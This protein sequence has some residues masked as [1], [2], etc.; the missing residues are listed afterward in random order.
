MRMKQSRGVPVAAIAVLAALALSSSAWGQ[1]GGTASARLV[2]ADG[3]AAGSMELTQ[4]GN[5]VSVTAI[6]RG[7][8]AGFHGF[9]IHATGRCDRPTFA[10]AGGHF[11]R[12]GAAH[13]T[14][15]GDLPPLLVTRRGTVTASFHADRFTVSQLL[16]AD[17]AAIVVH[18]AADNHANIPTDRYD[19]DPDAT[20]LA[21]GDA[22]PRIACG[23]LRPGEVF[24][25]TD[26][27]PVAARA[28]LMAGLGAPAGYV[29]LSQGP[30][31]VQL[32]GR[33]AGVARGFHGFH[34]H[35]R[36]SCAGPSFESAGGH[37]DRAGAAHPVHAG[38]LPTVLVDENGFGDFFFLETDRLRLADLLG[39]DGT[40]FVVHANADNFANIPS[41]RYDPD[42][43]AATTATGDA[44]DRI[45][46]GVVRRLV[47]CVITVRP[48]VLQAGRRTTLRVRVRSDGRP[49]ADDYVE[50]IGAGVD[51]SVPPTDERGR[52]RAPVRPQR[53]GHVLL[54]VS[55]GMSTLGCRA[56]VRVVGG[57]GGAGLTGRPT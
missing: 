23:V 4:F 33:V 55:R 38:D 12:T 8:P 57:A 31:G 17:G 11:D 3:S 51:R 5:G 46:C 43:D 25:I 52:L 42:P 2:R 35:E 18:A 28:D 14:H 41:D 29:L 40:A 37:F 26:D 16:D 27:Y 7:L 22:G 49:L 19:P 10:S 9:H 47:P 36:G 15:A 50:I 44:G 48:R 13:P 20:T 32:N 24:P 34:I 39:D 6:L 30:R 54:Q 56:R 1:L 21:T 45:A 53:R